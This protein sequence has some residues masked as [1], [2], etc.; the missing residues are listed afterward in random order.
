MKTWL[1]FD[2]PTGRTT[3]ILISCQLLFSI[4]N[5]YTRFQKFFGL[6]IFDSSTRNASAFSS[7]S[8]DPFATN[9]A[10]AYTF[11]Y[12]RRIS[13]K[14]VSLITRVSTFNSL[15]WFSKWCSVGGAQ[16]TQWRFWVFH[17]IS[18]NQ[19]HQLENP[20]LQIFRL[21]KLVFYPWNI[22]LFRL[23]ILILYIQNHLFEI[24]LVFRVLD[25]E[26]PMEDHLVLLDHFFQPIIFV[27]CLGFESSLL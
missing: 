5:C 9:F 27:P 2:R 7:K 15:K 3:A 26:E 25:F 11:L 16:W 24:H 17:L 10:S 4:F 23:V 13:M 19:K 8:F 18:S 14:S 6:F 20:P 1:I 22:R 12:S 21:Q